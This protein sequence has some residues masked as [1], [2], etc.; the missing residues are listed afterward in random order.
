[1][2]YAYHPLQPR[3]IPRLIS[4]VIPAYDEEET[5]PLLRPKL[6]ELLDTLPCL[7]EVI[8][9]NDGSRDRTMELLLRWAEEDPRIKVLGLARNFG[10]QAAVTAGLDYATGEAIVIM[11]A[12]LQ[13]PPHVVTQ[14]LDEYCRGY[15]VVYGQRT[16][17]EGEGP[18]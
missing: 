14:M 4:I 2:S 6:A 15:D 10:H 12:D 9:I 16:S 1:M 5:I 18:F 11:D 8:I 17:R 13:D 7:S 3:A